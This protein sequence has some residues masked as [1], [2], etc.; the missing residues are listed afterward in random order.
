[1]KIEKLLLQHGAAALA[2]IFLYKL[3]GGE[4]TTWVVAVV[5]MQLWWLVTLAAAGEWLKERR[6]KRYGRYE[7]DKPGSESKAS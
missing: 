6:E 5:C 3:L 7:R 4:D 1:M 2:T